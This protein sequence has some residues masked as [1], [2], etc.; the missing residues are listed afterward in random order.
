M[1]ASD[2][3]WIHRIHLLGYIRYILDTSDTFGYIRYIWMHRIHLN[4]SGYILHISILGLSVLQNSAYINL[5]ARYVCPKEVDFLAD[6]L[7]FLQGIQFLSH[8][9]KAKRL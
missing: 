1:D 7:L 5:L 2:T 9:K 3:F 8:R 6:N 4:T